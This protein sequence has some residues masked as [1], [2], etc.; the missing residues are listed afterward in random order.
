M[1]L[2]E[3]VIVITGATGGLGRVVARDFAAQG[4]RLALLSSNQSKLE[5]LLT[6]LALPAGRVF[7]HVAALHQAEG[8]ETAAAAVQH[9]FGRIDA[10]IH[11]VGG[12]VG[13]AQITAANPADLEAML[14][15]HVWSTFHVA[16]AFIPALIVNGWGRVIVVS[17]PSA[18]KPRARGGLYAA[19]KAAQEALILTLAQELKDS[20]VTANIIQVSTIDTQH[21]R[22][23]EPS[24]TNAGWTSPEEIS[25]AIGYLCSDAGSVVNGARIPLFGV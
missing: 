20:P 7:T 8:V 15:Q 5:A 19:A 12:W 13:G 14:A 4:A 1:T 18:Q 11:L 10:L 6:E 22:D 23:N 16:R 9:A 24:A 2:N 21:Q 17:S 25:A 3:R